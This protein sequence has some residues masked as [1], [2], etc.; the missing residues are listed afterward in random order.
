MY[1]YDGIIQGNTIFGLGIIS[2]IEEEYQIKE[3]NV[4]G[5]NSIYL[6]EKE[7]TY[8]VKNENTNKEYTSMQQ[9][10]DEANENEETTLTILKD[11]ILQAKFEVPENRSIILNLDGNTITNKY[12]QIINNG[13]LIIKD[14][15][16]EGSIICENVLKGIYNKGNLLV[17]GGIVSSSSY[18]YSYG[19][20]NSG[21]VNVSGGTVSSSSSR[22]EDVNSYGIY[23]SAGTVNVS[24]GTVSSSSSMGSN[25]FGHSYGI[26]SSAGTVNVSGGTVSSSNI[27]NNIY[28]YGIY[29]SAGTVNVYG[30]T[31]SNS[32]SN[33]STYSY[34]ICNNGTVNVFGGTVSSSNSS[35]RGCYGIYN[36]GMVNVFGGTVSSSSSYDAYGIYN[37]STGTMTLGTKGDGIVS[38]IE[39]NIKATYTGT[40]TSYGG[41]GIYNPKGSLYLY[42]GKIE[43]STL[44]LYTGSVI[45]EREENTELLYEDSD[46]ILTLTTDAI[47]IAKIGDTTYS[48]LQEAIDV[49]GTTQTTIELLRGI[50]YTN[51]DATVTITQNQ[52]ITLDLKGFSIISAIEDAVITNNGKLKITDTSENV[53]GRISSSFE[54]TIQNNQ[55]AI[56]ELNKGTITKTISKDN[57]VYNEGTLNITGATVVQSDNSGYPIYNIENATLNITEGNI[58]GGTKGIYNIGNANINGGTISNGITNTLSGILKIQNGTFSRTIENS[59]NACIEMTDGKI[60]VSGSYT[61]YGIKNTSTNS[62]T[63]SGGTIECNTTSSDYKA[64][65][66]YST[67]GTINIGTKDV[68]V[69]VTNPIILGTTNGIYSDCELNYYDGII[70]GKLSAISGNI[71]QIEEQCELVIETEEE[72]QTLTLTKVDLPIA[73]VDGNTYYT[74]KEA[75]NNITSEQTIT[76]L[77]AGTVSET[78]EIPA[79][80]NVTIDLNGNTLDMYMK[81]E[82]K[83]TLKITDSSEGATGI[84]KGYDNTPI[85]NDASL[86]LLNGTISGNTYGIYNNKTGTTIISGGVITGN[87]YGIYNVSGGTVNITNGEIKEN[88]YGV[89]NYGGTTNVEGGNITGNTYGVYSSTGTTNVTSGTISANT[90]GITNNSGTTNISNITITGNTNEVTNSGAGTINIISGTIIGSTNA[91]TNANSSGSINIGSQDGTVNK[92]T[93]VIQGEEYG[94]NNSGKGT[95][96]FYDGTIKGKMGAISGYYFYTETGYTSKT[97]EVDG[98]YCDTLALSGTVSTV[99]KIGDIEYTNLQ[100]AINACTSEEASIITLVN[101]INTSST[102]TIEEGQNVVIDLNGKTITSATADKT[103]QNDGTLKIIDSSGSNLGKITN[104][105][106]VAISNSGI[107]TL[108]E[109]EGTINVDCPEISG[110]TNGVI[111]AGTFNFYDGII[112]GSIALDGTITSRPDNYVVSKTTENGVQQLVL[113]K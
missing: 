37:S 62:I 107:L 68:N 21:T 17:E 70:K 104:T 59:E 29:S 64:Y 26:Y 95:I 101:S 103:I 111:N 55:G 15:S 35:D 84:L 77:R 16:S 85:N 113:T 63:I 102:F 109:D 46:K 11:F 69:D 8:I 65:G 36:Y 56:L 34:G 25:R 98:Y 28:S 9:A 7:E 42:D 80:K 82:N 74:L 61:Q 39:P 72:Y 67:A 24:G 14:F 32:N 66:I 71:T 73:S 41:Y 49:A 83:G 87:E 38:N 91:I 1:L 52:D 106:K 100:S 51:Q 94:I 86:E 33:S 90:Y 31:V 92:E 93:P 108:G 112:K 18:I 50:Q 22:G 79:E 89:F 43:G 81:L 76:I 48:S 20:Y 105:F 54:K 2:E 19:I 30:G 5:Y 12:W 44:A 13:E 75:I 96:A 57:V 99:A 110:N 60:Q 97:N 40:L 53:T 45:T 3:E 78:T 23:S 10:I 88:T 6:E 4:N 47:D 27:G 58:T